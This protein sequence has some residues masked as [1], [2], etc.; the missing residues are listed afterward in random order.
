MDTVIFTA[1]HY[2]KL[3]L[4]FSLWCWR[5]F[6][7]SMFPHMCLM[8]LF[9][10]L[11]VIILLALFFCFLLSLFDSYGFISLLHVIHSCLFLLH[12]GLS[13]FL[14][15]LCGVKW[16]WCGQYFNICCICCSFWCFSFF[17]W[18][19]LFVFAASHHSKMTFLYS[20][21]IWYMCPILMLSCMSLKSLLCFFASNI[22]ITLVYFYWFILD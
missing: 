10:F 6:L 17:H 15:I 2:S 16:C 3:F 1:L 11:L 8:L 14:Y 4:H 9:S 18:W 20:P 19:V 13:W 7:W 21:R 22:I 5:I 12:A